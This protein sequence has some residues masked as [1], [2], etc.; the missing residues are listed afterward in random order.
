MPTPIAMPKLGMTMQEGRVVAWPV[1]VGDRVEKGQVVLL[2]ESEK[3]EI[4]IEAP[5]SGILRHVYVEPDTTVPCGTLLAALSETAEEPFDSAEFQ[6]T[7]DRPQPAVAAR[8]AVKPTTQAIQPPARTAGVITPAARALARQLAI[9]PARV[10]GSGP[11]GRVTREDVEAWVARRKDLIEVAPGVSLEVPAAGTG[12]PLLLLPGFGTDVASFA[13]QTPV[14]IEHFRVLGVN[15]RGVGLSDAPADARYDVA[16]MAT[17]AAALLDQP[18]H[19]IGAS[20][21]AAAAIELALQRPDR[22]R[23]LTLITPFIE[24]NPRLLRVVDAWCRVAREASGETLARSLL[25]WLFSARFLADEVACER[26]VRG[27]CASVARVPATTLERTAAGMRAW[28]GSRC[29]DLARIAAPTMVLIAGDDLLT[30]G[31]A[32]V[33]AAIP[34]A[35]TKAIAGAGHALALEASEEV[36][37]AILTHLGR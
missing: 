33:A 30:P 5:A 12:D 36:N 26:T 19:V 32:A 15:P 28:S 4:E 3:T 6:R 29:D 7:H 20:L 27:L 11:G 1:R 16:V 35:T 13:R 24:A 34:H 25:A 37:A 14:L 8:P 31:G 22:V 18:A 2:I 9:D 21:G 23:S 10:P 17:D